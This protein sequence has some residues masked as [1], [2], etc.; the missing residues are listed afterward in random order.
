MTDLAV[1]EPQGT[2]GREFFR[3][4]VVLG[5]DQAK[6]P[7]MIRFSCYWSPEWLAEI[8]EGTRE[9]ANVCAIEQSRIAKRELTPISATLVA[10]EAA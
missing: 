5:D 3:W 6:E 8:P 1:V 2:Y 9:I 10:A 4:N 7:I